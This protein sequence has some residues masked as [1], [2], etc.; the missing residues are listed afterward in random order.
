VTWTATGGPLGMTPFLS[1]ARSFTPAYHMFC[2]DTSLQK[3]ETCVFCNNCSL[4]RGIR[5]P[6]GDT[7]N[8]KDYYYAGEARAGQGASRAETKMPPVAM[9]DK[10][11]VR[12]ESFRLQVWRSNRHGRVQWS[13]RLE[14]LQDGRHSQFNS[15]DA[16]LSHLHALL[17][18]E[19]PAGTLPTSWIEHELPVVSNPEGEE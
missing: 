13:A 10:A 11:P 1:L 2:C 9:E 12:Y 14:G 17:D 8:G 16:L 6:P 4:A 18:P 15:P 5:R 19:Q 7:R 3:I